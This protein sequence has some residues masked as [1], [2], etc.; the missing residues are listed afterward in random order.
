VIDLDAHIV[1][2]HSEKQQA[3]P[4]F[5]HSF[6]YHTTTT[7]ACPFSGRLLEGRVSTADRKLSVRPLMAVSGHNLSP[8][9]ACERS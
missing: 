5:K 2:C 3:A 8:S 6:G 1:V 4:T 7:L 9:Q